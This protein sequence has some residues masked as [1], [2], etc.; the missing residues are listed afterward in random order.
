MIQKLKY[1]NHLDFLR[2]IAVLLVIFFHLDIS[3]FSGG[4]IGVDVFFVISGYLITRNIKFEYD[5]TKK[6]DF[7]KF[8]LGRVRRL[9]PTLLLMLLF[10]FIL[11]FL[12]FS[13]SLFTGFI[14]SMFFS[15][16]A[17]S[18]FY[19]LSEAN[20]FDTASSLKPLLHT[21]SLGIEEQFYL[22]YPI[23]FFIIIKIF[24]KT[25]HI[26]IALIFVF[27]LSFFFNIISNTGNWDGFINFFI[28]Q[29]NTQPNIASLQFYLLPFR[30]FEF[31]AGGILVFL[32][33]KKD[34]TGN[35]KSILSVLGLLIIV[36][37]AIIFDADTKYMSTL[38]L[39]PCVGASLFILNVPS[40][41]IN[42]IYNLSFF[43]ITGNISY[44]LYLFHWPLIVFY[45]FVTGKS[46]GFLD[47]MLLIAITYVI[48]YFVYNYYENPIRN[49]N[50]KTRL[51]SNPS[52]LGLILVF[53]NLMF[54]LKQDVTTNQGWLWR[55][56]K[57]TIEFAKKLENPVK[58][59]EQNWGAAGY[60]HDFIGGYKTKPASMI[61]LGDSHAGHYSYG[62][63]SIMVKKNRK[64]VYMNYRLSVLNLPG[65][66]HKKVDSSKVNTHLNNV[67]RIIDSNPK[68]LV[69]LSHYWD[70]Q[71]RY[72]KVNI[73]N[74]YNDLTI[75]SVGYKNLCDK[76]VKFSHLV[77]D[78][79]ILVMGESPFKRE[80]EIS[81]IDNLLAPKYFNKSTSISSYY[82][83]PKEVFEIN[84]YFKGYF[85]KHKNI[86]F[87]DPAAV[88][89]KEGNCLEQKAN[90][91]YFSDK[92]HLSKTG[93][94][95][96]IKAIEKQLME[97]V[98]GID[99]KRVFQYL[100]YNNI[101]N[102]DS[103]L[104]NFKGWYP[105]EANHRWGSGKESEIS[106]NIEDKT[107]FTGVI[108]I[109]A[110]IFKKQEVKFFINDKFIGSKIASGWNNT[111]VFNFEPSIL[112]NGENKITFKYL[113]PLPVGTQ[114][115]NRVL[116]FAF[117]NIK[118]K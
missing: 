61:W 42:S 40:K 67:L 47:N 99:T 15:S 11:S 34:T 13:P 86:H 22:L 85:E 49:R 98:I 97:L 30:V 35:I 56:D 7:K 68:S 117:K 109:G 1:L 107:L 64:S 78:R 75:D 71:I 73:N 21:W 92:N 9:I 55:L 90:D 10:A 83:P 66:I 110:G 43:K 50:P 84:N 91:I 12:F 17:L 3:F 77:G 100:K 111:F 33:N 28:S 82:T 37:S 46:L 108:E 103:P 29:D 76:I 101:I 74:L 32:T 57:E 27:L 65:F 44:T 118:I 14:N 25:K 24:N 53:I 23:L 18:N 62:L 116:A 31:L 16:I 54:Y 95:K 87:I 63:D 69:V 81:F 94:L 4:F 112:N 5:T 26:L 96:A 72:S 80:S 6:V 113:N 106:F 51:I 115:D 88:F 102:H 36:S 8:Y 58:Y 93:S 45:K 114:N 39:I 2:A 48:A 104:L 38:N 19:F 89:C 59:N 70:G 60:K 52:L 105:A 41:K 20:Y 79:N